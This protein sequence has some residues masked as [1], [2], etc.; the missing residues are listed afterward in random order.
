MPPRATLSG[1]E[2]T[3]ERGLLTYPGVCVTGVFKPGLV[4]L[5]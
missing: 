5:T 3:E 2:A 4:F 1:E